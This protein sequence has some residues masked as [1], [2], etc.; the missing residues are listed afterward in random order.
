VKFIDAVTC[1]IRLVWLRVAFRLSTPL[2]EEASVLLLCDE[3]S[4]RCEAF[5]WCCSVTATSTPRTTAR[6]NGPAAITVSTTGNVI[7]H[8]RVVPL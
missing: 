1:P 7:I 5:H 2:A 8:Q 6:S 4:K 3:R